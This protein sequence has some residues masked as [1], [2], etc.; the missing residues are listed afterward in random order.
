V[1]RYGIFEQEGERRGH[2][3]GAAALTDEG[4]QR[5]QKCYDRYLSTSHPFLL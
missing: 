3:D 1:V 5:D 4:E 2:R